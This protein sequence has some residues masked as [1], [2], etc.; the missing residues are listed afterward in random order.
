MDRPKIE[1]I[2]ITNQDVL[3]ES[4]EFGDEYP[5]TPFENE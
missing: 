1:I 4:D 2:V 3:T 5:F